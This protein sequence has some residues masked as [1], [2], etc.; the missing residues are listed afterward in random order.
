MAQQDTPTTVQVKLHLDEARMQRLLAQ[1]HA[2]AQQD[3]L[4]VGLQIEALKN[5]ALSGLFFTAL[6]TDAPEHASA[7]RFWRGYV[8]ALQDLSDGAGYGAALRDQQTSGYQPAGYLKAAFAALP[9]HADFATVAQVQ[10]FL[11][12]QGVQ[13]SS[14]S[15]ADLQVGTVQQF[16][17]GEGSTIDLNDEHAAPMVDGNDGALHGELPGVGD[18]TTV[19]QEGGA[20]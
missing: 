11:A 13:L 20:A 3:P 17:H 1:I 9:V 8:K 7:F 6:H 15:V 10:Q 19:A 18:A 4:T 2:E 14:D 16:E 5:R 12:S